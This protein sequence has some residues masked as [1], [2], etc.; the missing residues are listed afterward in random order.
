MQ[1]NSEG[2]ISAVVTCSIAVPNPGC[3]EFFVLAR[4]P[5]VTV[6]YDFSMNYLR[7]WPKMHAVV[8]KLIESFFVATL[9]PT[10]NP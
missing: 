4:H 10:R 1:K 3:N 7:E 9:P 6:D 5:N 8:E 2:E